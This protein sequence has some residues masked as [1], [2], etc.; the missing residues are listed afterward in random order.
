MHNR[1]VGLDFWRAILLL[2]GVLL[3]TAGRIRAMPDDPWIFGVIQSLSRATRMQAF[4]LIAGYLAAASISKK[5]PMDWL[6]SRTAQLLIPFFVVWLTFQ[7][8][9]DLIRKGDFFATSFNIDHLWF[10]IVLMSFS[11][12]TVAGKCTA[13]GK[14]LSRAAREL[15]RLPLASVIAG[16]VAAVFAG[17]LL[18][19][20]IYAAFPAIGMKEGNYES[21][22]L[23]SRACVMIV[24]YA[25]GHVLYKADLLDRV[26]VA[27][28]FAVA[29]VAMALYLMLY[30]PETYTVR[31]ITGIPNAVTK[32]TTYFLYS[33]IGTFFSL[34]IFIHA[35]S[36][37]RISK[38]TAYLSRAAYTIYLVHIFYVAAAFQVL[39]TILHDHYL[40]F[41]GTVMLATACSLATHQIISMVPML[42]LLFNGKLP[43]TEQA[44]PSFA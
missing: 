23:L 28:L 5:Q 25:V 40:L 32:V 33:V 3:H 44:K 15:R 6:R 43:R 41:I 21:L 27:P 34:A 1:L 19:Q 17:M 14:L 26:R 8:F 2:Y 38:N 24:F 11:L 4:F 42:R 13:A 20:Y 16:M 29:A 12:L 10:L 22:Y 35:R 31:Q 30:D 9:T 18:N 36:I 39:S 37:T 7:R